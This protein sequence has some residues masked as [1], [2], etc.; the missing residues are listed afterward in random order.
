MQQI[1]KFTAPLLITLIS[2]FFTASY[3]GL[4]NL[5]RYDRDA[6]YRGEIWRILTGNLSHA[7]M[8]HWTVNMIGLWLLWY[9]YVD[10]QQKQ[11]KML[12]VLFIAS[13]GTCTGILFLEPQLKWYVGLSGAL[14]GLFAAGIVLSFRSEPKIQFLLAILLGSK[15]VYEQIIGPL[16]GSEQTTGIPVIVNSHLYGAIT[17]II[18]GYLM[19]LRDSYKT[20]TPSK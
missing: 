3:G 19:K 1:S 2:V 5:L 10:S 16:P 15:L 7:G 13:I 9:I 11:L 18:T 8:G 17:G 14:H 6:I 20:I 4:Y 12:F